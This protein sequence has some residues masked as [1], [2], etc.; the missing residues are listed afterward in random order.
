MDVFQIFLLERQSDAERDKK[1]SGSSKITYTHKT[2]KKKLLLVYI[3]LFLM[4]NP[5]YNKNKNK[6]Q[7]TY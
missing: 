1:F 4:Q 2:W 3:E 7:L 5:N 6:R